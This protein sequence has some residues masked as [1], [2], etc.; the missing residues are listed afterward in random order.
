MIKHCQIPWGHFKPVNQ[1]FNCLVAPI[2]CIVTEHHFIKLYARSL[3]ICVL[4]HE[5]NVE[6]CQTMHPLALYHI[7]YSI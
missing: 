5:L 2:E 3:M 4:R 6:F 1:Q 7:W